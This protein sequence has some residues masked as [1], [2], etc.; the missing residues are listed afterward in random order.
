MSNFCSHHSQ[1]PNTLLRLVRQVETPTPSSPRVLGI[2]DWALRKGA[3]YGTILVDLEA[4]RI[5]DLLP[6]RQSETVAA[7]LE[8]RPE[9]EV[10]SRDRASAYAEAATTGA[11]QATQ[12][13]DR[14]HLLRNLG[15]AL[16]AILEPH[17]S[18]LKQVPITSALEKSPTFP[19]VTIQMLGYPAPTRS[20]YQEPQQQRRQRRLERYEMVHR[21]RGLGWTV[22]SIA[23]ETD[24]D[25]KTVRRFLRATT[26]PERQPRRV[27][28]SILDSYK[29]YLLNRWNQG[30]RTGAQLLRE[31]RTQG[32]LGGDTLVNA[33]LAQVRRVQGL[34]PKT[35]MVTPRHPIQ[36]TTEGMFTPRRATWLVLSRPEELEPAEKQRLANLIEALPD[37]EQAVKLSRE[38]AAMLRQRHSVQLDAWLEQVADSPYLPLRNFAKGIRC[39]Y[40]AVKAA[41]SL[42]WSNG[43]TEGHINRLKLVKRQMYGRASFDLLKRRVLYAN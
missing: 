37:L 7:W 21:L 33:F 18:R 13:A 29:P 36:G 27:Q 4:S 9:I 5:V 1:R 12:V 14:W 30:C 16:V 43:A 23:I 42:K 28:A 22:S 8:K 20:S 10:I 41:L 38:F 34:P 39:D 25:P 24:L 11:P 26:F 32:Y 31:I 3:S 17:Q 19:P 40:Q 35:R 6:S 15:E 2:D